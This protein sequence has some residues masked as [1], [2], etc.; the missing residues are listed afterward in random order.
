MEA[1]GRTRVLFGPEFYDPFRLIP[2]GQEDETLFSMVK[3]TLTGDT[4]T[5][6][7]ELEELSERTL[8][9]PTDLAKASNDG[10]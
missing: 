9:L 2:P 3:G 5:A 8:D 7:A 10:P 1:N 4:E 6:E